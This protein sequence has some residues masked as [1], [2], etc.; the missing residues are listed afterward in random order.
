MNI[1]K[2]LNLHFGTTSANLGEVPLKLE[3]DAEVPSGLERAKVGTL[4]ENAA[5]LSFTDKF[6]T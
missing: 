1:N 5:T 6:I 4:V 2:W 3:I